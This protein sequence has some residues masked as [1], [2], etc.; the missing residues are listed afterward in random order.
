LDV[1]AAFGAGVRLAGLGIWTTHLVI[2]TRCVG[3]GNGRRRRSSCCRR[4][5]SAVEG[6][7]YGGRDRTAARVWSGVLVRGRT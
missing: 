7:E 1:L 6:P 3:P 2:N 4:P 5:S